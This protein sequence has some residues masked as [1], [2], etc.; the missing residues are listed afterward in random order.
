[1]QD[2]G[3]G[4]RD[5]VAIP[6][7]A[8]RIAHRV[9]SLVVVLGGLLAC[10]AAFGSE[11]GAPIDVAPKV[12]GTQL[13]LWP[14]AAWA[15]DSKS[16]LVVWRE[17]YINEE[18]TDVWCARVSADPSTGS[19]GSPQAGSGLVGK[20]LDPAGIKVCAAKDRQ[21][22]AVVASDGKGWLVVWEDFRNGKDYDVYAARVSPEGRVLDP[23][24]FLIAGDDPS[25]PSEA[26]GGLRR[27]GHNQCKPDAAWSPSTGSGQDGGSWL[28]AWRSYELT[29]NAWPAPHPTVKLNRY[30]AFG[31]RVGSDGK[32]RDA[33]PIGI[34]SF[35]KHGSSVTEPRVASTASTAS[36]GSGQA[37]SG[38]AGSG[39]LVAWMGTS[40]IHGQ[41]QWFRWGV[42]TTVVTADGQAKQ[43]DTFDSPPGPNA[44]VT[45]ASNGKDGCLIAWDNHGTGGRSGAHQTDHAL[46]TDF[47]GKD[48]GHLLLSSGTRKDIPIW[49]SAAAWDGKGYV[50]AGWDG[51]IRSGDGS[52]PYVSRVVAHLVSDDGKYEGVVEVSSGKPNPGYFPAA[53]GDGKG[54]TLVVYERHPEKPGDTILIAA[55]LVKR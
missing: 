18:A 51:N 26:A 44:P 28:V 36:T 49:Q 39:W 43:V 2:T 22:R 10:G 1:M 54:N 37:G 32:V 30:L 19:T 17:G 13:Q 23:D 7:R 11:A 24:G 4:I 35:M 27:T 31:V 50:V 48:L 8:S 3:F 21:E 25:S 41:T 9:F 45:I 52:R 47:Q 6:H 5:V 34:G 14:R 38:Q 40:L 55:K 33:K 53:C 15:A 16:W 12:A 42:Y 20:A 29:P 46:R